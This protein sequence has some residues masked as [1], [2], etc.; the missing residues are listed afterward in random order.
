VS[1]GGGVFHEGVGVLTWHLCC[2]ACSKAWL[3]APVRLGGMLPAKPPRVAALKA[4]EGLNRKESDIMEAHEFHRLWAILSCSRS[5]AA[6]PGYKLWL[7]S[8]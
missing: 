4:A 1:G 2:S 3:S 8:R 5:R 7:C 6:A